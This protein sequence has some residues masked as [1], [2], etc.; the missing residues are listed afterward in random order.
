MLPK[1]PGQMPITSTGTSLPSM[2]QHGIV[3]PPIRVADLVS[4]DGICKRPRGRAPR[5]KVWDDSKGM[6]VEA[7]AEEEGLASAHIKKKARV[8]GAAAGVHSPTEDTGMV[9]DSVMTETLAPEE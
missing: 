8:E 7:V 5:G 9:E 1:G 3:P 6:W 2:V 4:K